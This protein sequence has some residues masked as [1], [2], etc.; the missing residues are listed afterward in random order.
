M[1]DERPQEMRGDGPEP[2]WVRPHWEEGQDPPGD[3]RWARANAD[4]QGGSPCSSQV[5]PL[6]FNY[7]VFK[8]KRSL[9]SNTDGSEWSKW[10]LREGKLYYS[11]KYHSKPWIIFKRHQRD[12]SNIQI[13]PVF[14]K[15]CC[16]LLLTTYY[17]LTVQ[18][19]HNYIY[20]RSNLVLR[21]HP[22][23][24]RKRQKQSRGPWTQP[25]TRH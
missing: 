10:S 17:S 15:I 14:K 22:A 19:N 6:S 5:L 2:V 1:W 18:M 24:R 12:F 21:I 23:I 20:S 4:Y 11:I 13:C 7:D 25:G 9:Q 16:P 8:D 3:L